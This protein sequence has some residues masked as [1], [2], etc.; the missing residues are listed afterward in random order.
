VQPDRPRALSAALLALCALLLLAA[1]TTHALEKVVL[2]LKW[3][4]EFQFAGYYAALWEGYYAREGLDVELRP[5]FTSDGRFLDTTRE[6]VAGNAQFAIG[7]V[8]ILMARGRGEDLVVLAPIFQRSPLAAFALE[9]TPLARPEDLRDLRLAIY[10]NDSSAID[11]RALL[12]P[13]G[14]D[15]QSLERVREPPL[16]DTLVAEK[17]DVIVTY[18]VAAHHRAKELGVRLNALHP[19]DFG[20]QGYGD[21]LYTTGAVARTRPDL[22]ERFVRASLE[23]WRFAHANREELAERI[24]TSLPRYAY[25]F[26]DIA[27]YNRTFAGLLDTYTLYPGVD[28]GSLDRNRWERTYQQLRQARLIAVPFELDSL[29]VADRARAGEPERLS[30]LPWLLVA[31]AALLAAVLAWWRAGFRYAGLLVLVLIGGAEFAVESQ[32]REEHLR[33]QQLALTE[34]LGSVRARLENIVN[35]SL[36]LTNGLAAFIAVNPDLDQTAFDAYARTVLLREPALVNLAAAP[37]LVVRFVYP[38]EG[39][40]VVMGTDY[41]SVPAQREAAERVLQTGEMVVAGP[42]ELLQ[43]GQALI[44]RVPVYV[45]RPGVP[46]RVW[47]IVSAPIRVETVLRRAG[48]DAPPPGMRIALRGRDGRGAEGEVFHG[49]PAVFDASEAVRMQ[50]NVGAGAWQIAALP[51]IGPRDAL[52]LWALRFFALGLGALS[53]TVIGARAAQRR[54]ELDYAQEME[55]QAKEDALTGLPNRAWFR[56]QLAAT[57]ARSTR[58]HSRHALLFIDLDDFKS[59]NDNLGHDAGDRLLVEVADRIRGCLRSSDTVARQSGDEFTAILYDITS[60]DAS[61]HVAESIVEALGRAY[62]IGGNEVFCGASIGVAIYPDDSTD[63]DTLI[64]KADQA[65]YSVKQSGRNGW[66]FYTREMHEVSERRHRLYNEL[67]AAIDSGE[68][69]VWLQPIVAV[70]DGR[71]VSCEALARWQ[72]ANGS[73]VPPAEFVEVAE[74]RGLVN[75]LDLHIMRRAVEELRALN[76]AT[77]ASVGLSVN[78]SPR[79]LLARN[80]ELARWMEVARDAARELRL[81]VEITER[82]LLGES[83]QAHRVLSELAAAQVGVSIDDFG[84]GFSSLGYLMRFPVDTLK[85]D[86]SFVSGVGADPACEAVVETILAMAHRLGKRVVAEGVETEAQWEYLRRHGCSFAQGYLLGK[87]MSPADFLTALRDNRAR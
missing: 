56:Q 5:A 75:R 45:D 87:P 32:F 31:A 21:T 40:E 54:R 34:Q 33:R 78:V 9:G 52:E 48:L 43:G 74:E 2:Q 16:V 19:A 25:R 53:L 30:V 35:I 63:P 59:V 11:L 85:I 37:D 8:D 86:R 66:H 49:D 80:P 84:T 61:A 12:Q 65:M 68:V 77:G 50:V 23:G 46:R 83:E 1:P 62:L 24:S 7:A 29:F 72:R 41:R 47:G 57:L 60:T 51:V 22:V 44:G 15:F 67:A 58:S 64:T 39:N 27:G 55:R 26:D 82:L 42:V 3:E 79:L 14:I 4:H 28:I 6:L 73:W 71:I 69:Q 13:H 18:A 36:S 10:E 70:A 76:A 81:S 38:Q 20:V 17:A